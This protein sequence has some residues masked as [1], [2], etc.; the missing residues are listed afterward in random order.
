MKDYKWYDDN[1]T[2]CMNLKNRGK[3]S[4]ENNQE[5]NIDSANKTEIELS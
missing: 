3:V 4:R 1:I 5:I 2:Y